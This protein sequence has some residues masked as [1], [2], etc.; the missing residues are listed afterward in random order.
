MN[1]DFPV[2]DWF[3]LILLLPLFIFIISS[4]FPYF[5]LFVSI[6]IQSYVNIKLHVSTLY[7]SYYYI[8]TCNLMLTKLIGLS[9]RNGLAVHSE[10]QAK[11]VPKIFPTNEIARNKIC[12]ADLLNGHEWRKV[13]CV[14]ENKLEFLYP[15]VTTLSF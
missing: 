9:I 10:K 7:R 5:N 1:I 6:F 13:G 11:K 2:V 4:L 3:C 14:V 15:Y 8:D 12:S